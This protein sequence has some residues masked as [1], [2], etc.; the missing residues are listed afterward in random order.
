MKIMQALGLTEDKILERVSL[1]RP[2]PQPGEALIAVQAAAFN[3]RE[4]WITKGLY[5]GMSLPCTLGADG[6]GRIVGLGRGVD[7]AWMGK[8]V[9][10][11]PGVG[12]GDDP[13]APSRAFRLFGMPEQGFI[14]D[15]ICVPAENLVEKPE[16]LSWEEAAAIPVASLTAWRGLVRHGRVHPD[17]N[18]LITGVGGG[19]AQAVMAFGQAFGANI[20][21]TSGTSEK[22][23]RAVANGAVAGFN[24]KDESWPKALAT[25]SGGI[26]IVLDSS[27]TA[28]FDDYLPFLKWGARVVVFGAHSVRHTSLHISRF[29]LRHLSLIGTALGTIEEF[30][31]MIA[32]MSEHRV[33]PE[34][35]RTFAFEQAIEAFKYLK[36]GQHVGKIIVNGFTHGP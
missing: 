36:S 4:I 5:P 28:N 10:C 21:V 13:Q 8:S 9:V 6:A 32:F 14:A 19:V 25:A 11:Y 16:Y 15:Y 24:Y 29:F 35:D 12:W 3:H 27:P 33:R 34:L 20:Y 23:D 17:D 2:R 18:V 26:D 7:P 1:E 31:E 30:Q 22:I